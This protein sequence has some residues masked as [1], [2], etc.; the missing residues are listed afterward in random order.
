VG[1]G[2]FTPRSGDTSFPLCALVEA[3][4]MHGQGRG[5]GLETN[6]RNASP[7][8]AAGAGAALL[9]RPPALR[10]RL[11]VLL[12]AEGFGALTRPQFG[13]SARRVYQGGPAGGRFMVGLTVRLAGALSPRKH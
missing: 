1:R 2:C 4:A 12:R 5:S 3:G 6:Q 8:A 13:T 7:W 11:G 10:E 9:W